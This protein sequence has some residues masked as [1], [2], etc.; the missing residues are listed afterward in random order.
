MLIAGLFFVAVTLYALR[1]GLVGQHGI[2][3]IGFDTES[4]AMGGLAVI[5]AAFFFGPMYGLAL[6]LS[7]AIHEFGHVAAF[8]VAGHADARFR[9]VPLMG[10]YAISDSLPSTQKKAFFIALMGPGISVA[11]MVLAFGLSNYAWRVSPQAGQFLD[12]FAHVTAAL[13]FFNLLPFWPLDGGRCVRMIAYTF[14]PGL[15]NV[16][17]IAMSAG[18]A[19][20]ALM[21]QSMILFFFAL[22]GA[23]SVMHADTISRVQ[24]RM[25]WKD[26]LLCTAAYVFTAAA[27]LWGGWWLI[28]RYL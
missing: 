13:N 3:I 28:L 20:A 24:T 26:G 14:W 12:I 18:L 8:R 22:M 1:G 27:H 9:L 19:A 21:M 25:S 6:V 10:G 2:T 5:A 15:A 16:L 7:V 4:I 11:P 23:Q 17:T